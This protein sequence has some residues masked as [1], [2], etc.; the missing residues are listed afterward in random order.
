MRWCTLPA[1]ASMQWLSRLF[2]VLIPR[3]VGHARVFAGEICCCGAFCPC[4]LFGRMLQQVRPSIEL[5]PNMAEAHS[6]SS[7]ERGV[8]NAHKLMV[9]WCSC[10]MQTRL[11]SAP[12]YGCCTL[13]D[14]HVV[15]H[16]SLESCTNYLARSLLMEAITMA[17]NRYVL[18]PCL[19]ADG[20]AQRHH[21]GRSHWPSC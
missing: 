6:I 1:L 18:W 5:L 3:V 14:Y 11:S 8:I 13:S 7:A 2:S 16:K 19:R 15:D 10:L 20:A 17:W 21:S 4:W 9:A 12:V